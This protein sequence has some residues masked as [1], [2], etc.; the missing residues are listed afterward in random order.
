MSFFSNS[1]RTA[2][3]IFAAAGTL[4]AEAPSAPGIVPLARRM[5]APGNLVFRDAPTLDLGVHTEVYGRLV[6]TLV[7]L[8]PM[9]V[10]GEGE[11]PENHTLVRV[12][13][14]YQACTAQF[15]AYSPA[16]TGGVR[17]AAAKVNGDV[18]IATAPIACDWTRDLR[19]FRRDGTLAL[20]IKVRETLDSATLK[21]GLGNQTLRRA[22]PEVHEWLPPFVIA[23]GHFLSSSEDEQ[24]AV[25]RRRVL[26]GDEP[27]VRLY[28]LKDGALLKEFAFPWSAGVLDRREMHLAVKHESAR[29][30][31]IVQEMHSKTV[32]FLDFD[33]LAY[34]CAQPGG[35]SAGQ[36]VYESAF[37]SNGVVA[38]GP[39]P[40][41]STVTPFPSLVKAKPQDAG[42]HENR[43]WYCLPDRETIGTGTAVNGKYVR[44]GVHCHWRID[45]WGPKPLDPANNDPACW[46][47]NYFSSSVVQDHFKQ[48]VP[49]N[50]QPGFINGTFAKTDAQEKDEETGLL[51][52]QK[53]QAD[54]KTK[55]GIA[56][57]PSGDLAEKFF[58]WRMRSMLQ[59]LAVDVRRFDPDTNYIGVS[60]MHEI[61]SG[62]DWNPECIR[63]Y[64][65]YLLVK[66]GSLENI[67]RRFGTAFKSLRLSDFDA[68]RGGNRGKWDSKASDYWRE[69][70]I[71]D[72]YTVQ[73]MQFRGYR[74][75]LLAGLP[76]E[77]VKGHMIPDTYVYGGDFT[78]NREVTS[79]GCP[80]EAMLTAGVSFGCTRY[81]LTFKRPFNWL[82]GVW[83][84]GHALAINGEYGIYTESL[85]EEGVQQTEWLFEHGLEFLLYTHPEG[86]FG[87]KETLEGLARVNASGRPRPGVTGGVGE[88]RATSV[89]ER[90]YSRAETSGAKAYVPHET[91][92]VRPID[93]VAIGT[94]PERGG[95]LKSV[96]QQGFWDGLVYLQPFHSHIDVESLLNLGGQPDV[97][98]DFAA[99]A[100]HEPNAPTHKLERAGVFQLFN[101]FH[102][103]QFEIRFTA[104]SESGSKLAISAFSDCAQ[105][106]PGME[107][108][109]N[110]LWFDHKETGVNADAISAWMRDKMGGYEMPD[111]RM[112]IEVGHD[113]KE[114]RYVFS[115]QLPAGCVQMVFSELGARA[116]VEFREVS[117]TLQRETAARVAYGV[118]E[119]R[120]HRGGVTFDLLSRDTIPRTGA[121]AL[122]RSTEIEGLRQ[123]AASA[124][125]LRFGGP[126][127]A[128]DGEEAGLPAKKYQAHDLAALDAAVSQA[129]QLT[130][131]ANAP[132]DKCRECAA[133]IVKLRDALRANAKPATF[134][135]KGPKAKPAVV[136]RG[137][138][139]WTAS[140]L[141]KGLRFRESNDRVR[142][143]GVPIP[144]TCTIEL[145]VRLE[146][147]IWNGAALIS[148]GGG[149]LKGYW[150][151]Y[152][153]LG[154]DNGGAKGIEIF[155]PQPGGKRYGPGFECGK[156]YRVALVKLGTKVTAYVDGTK[157]AEG[158]APEHWTARGPLNL[159]QRAS[160]LDD[161]R[162]WDTARTEAELRTDMNTPLKGNEP[163]LIACWSFETAE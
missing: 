79:T 26:G 42:E 31:L 118:P 8:G 64:R 56:Y 66:Y 154:W 61:G 4:F 76:P 98:T 114:Y 2:A 113:W 25:A 55:G 137:E 16:V 148:F 30:R 81:A 128:R 70:L 132:A 116:A 65:D 130:Q 38:T 48:L 147:S 121:G 161:L 50:Y 104:R 77:S 107:R 124:R 68:P 123:C 143:D 80:I 85:P 23:T 127:G 28:S 22:A 45:H 86:M 155:A 162:I 63:G 13:N 69:W 12:Y 87:G 90:E 1:F 93:I 112:I 108:R 54:N 73:T 60:P 3:C 150:L 97:N 5:E 57:T 117:V 43:F 105:P 149:A 131:D 135:G 96:D 136:V 17:V 144:D 89:M 51:K 133:Q 7:P 49:S 125:K 159:G 120:A 126:S 83:S 152:R 18:L 151:D 84:S 82:Q 75:C 36:A 106:Q 14:R 153:S 88:V 21:Q 37:V 41:L 157:V 35:L 11:N 103:D 59:N 95:L 46:D 6:P 62:G 58:F 15:L 78:G 71:Y 52:Y 163:G 24:L 141:G 158:E 19:V 72:R 29:D 92:T 44:P 111:S 142:I 9:L 94:G 34:A 53:L 102:N 33:S 115:N 110:V 140:P 156:W 99:Q 119:G 100:F 129:D 10:A 101:L 40:V 47:Y 139:H 122:P 134:S 146:K 20:L 27:A 39:E 138:P 32:A 67:N 91:G 145:M 160:S 109:C 74:E